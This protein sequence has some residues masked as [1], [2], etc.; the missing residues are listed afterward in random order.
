VPVQ[1]GQVVRGAGEQRFAFARGEAAPG[2]HGEVLA[3]FSCPNTGS[4]VRAANLVVVAA[5]RMLY[6]PPG[7]GG[8]RELVQVQGP[9]RRAGA[10][11]AGVF[12]QRRQQPQPVGVGAGE[13]LLA[14]VT[15]VGEHG[16]QPRF[17]PGLG[18]LL[19]AGVQ[20]GVQPGLALIGAGAALGGDDGLVLALIGLVA[21][22]LG[23]LAEG[24]V[25]EE[26]NR[27]TSMIAIRYRGGDQCRSR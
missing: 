2:H 19:A 16:L 5:A 15:G 9:F 20:Q 14:D 27:Y 8:S 22:S 23:Q 10:V 4:T 13:G 26:N 25:R 11:P 24:Q 17:H 7:S 6:P 21:L 3:G 18:Q 12:S 1:L